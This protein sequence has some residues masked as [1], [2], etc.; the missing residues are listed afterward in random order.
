M[1]KFNL[2]TPVVNDLSYTALGVLGTMINN[3]LCDYR[4][5]EELCQFF[6]SDTLK[7][8]RSALSELAYKGYVIAFDNHTFAVNKLKITEMKVI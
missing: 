2:I 5:A 1:S 8:I 6:E 3:P 7:T 4:T